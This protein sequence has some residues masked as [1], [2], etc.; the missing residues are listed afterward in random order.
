MHHFKDHL[1]YAWIKENDKPILV[2]NYVYEDGGMVNVFFV[3]VN[4]H[5]LLEFIVLHCALAN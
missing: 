4:S 1:M 5:Q 3:F 2:E